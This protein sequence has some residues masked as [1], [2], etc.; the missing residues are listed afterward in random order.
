[1][2]SIHILVA[3]DN[4]ADVL[5]MR[6]ILDQMGLTYTH[7]VTEDGE[8]TRDYL[9][10]QAAY[11]SAQQP[12]LILLD[13]NLPRYTGLEVLQQVP[14]SDKL[15]VCIVTGTEEERRIFQDQFGSTVR[16]YIVKPLTP[17]KILLCLL[18]YEHLQAIVEEL[19]AVR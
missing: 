3:E 10:K 6:T 14:D 2:R 11:V 12:D 15:P 13:I 17:E 4:P 7:T 8:K 19:T 18:C 16:V 5:Q 9:L 1:M